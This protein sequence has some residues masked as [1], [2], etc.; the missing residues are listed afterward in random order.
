[1]QPMRCNADIVENDFG[2]P[3]RQVRPHPEMQ[4]R[5]RDLAGRELRARLRHS[6]FGDL[7]WLMPTSGIDL[8]DFAGDDLADG[9]VS[10]DQAETTSGQRKRPVEPLDIFRRELA[11]L[12]QTIDRHPRSTREELWHGTSSPKVPILAQDIPV[13]FLFDGRTMAFITAR[14]VAFICDEN[15]SCA[16]A[17]LRRGSA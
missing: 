12:Q 16:P 9:V 3:Q 4:L 11:F 17:H 2:Y 10:V 7:V 13:A 5:K 15:A 1:M 8:D 6:Q 14:I